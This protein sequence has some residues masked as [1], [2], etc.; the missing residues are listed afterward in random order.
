MHGGRCRR[1]RR[2]ARALD[3]C[4]RRRAVGRDG[5]AA[6]HGRDDALPSD[7]RRRVPARRRRSRRS[8]RARR[9]G[10]ALIAGT[11]ADEMRLFVDS[12]A[13]P[14]PRDKLV[15]RAA[16]YLG[17]DETDATPYR[18]RLRRRARHRRHA[19]R[20]GARSSATTRCSARAGPSSTRT[21][22]TGRR[23][24]TASRGAARR[25]ARATASTSRSRSATSSTAGTRSSV[26]TTTAARCHGRCATPGPRSPAPA[27]P[28]GPR[29]PRR[30]ASVARCTT[31][32]NTP[33]RTAPERLRRGHPHQQC[34]LRQSRLPRNSVV[35]LRVCDFVLVELS[36]EGASGRAA[37][38]ALDGVRRLRERAARDGL[39]EVHR[40]VGEPRVEARADD[41]A[42]ASGRA[43]DR[44]ASRR[45]GP[46]PRRR[47]APPDR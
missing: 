29:T 2:A 18:R 27:T 32:T 26:S 13:A 1:A 39:E 6:R 5:F 7:G 14:A 42:R 3:R 35:E 15:R 22:R 34:A 46:R 12:S 37:E 4:A 20:S 31:S 16:R 30:A 23:T 41:G 10:V 43:E 38:D 17:V 21:R 45:D 11:T 47:R 19:T 33:V 28:A 24:P 8:R 9:A 44:C 36:G 25:S 40:R